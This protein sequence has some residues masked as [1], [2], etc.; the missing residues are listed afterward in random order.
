MKTDI[1]KHVSRFVLAGAI[2]GAAVMLFSSPAHAASL[3]LTSAGRSGFLD[4][5]FF[6]EGGTLSGTGVFPAF[7][8]VHPGGSAVTEAAY[9]TTANNVGDNGSSDTF[10]HSIQF[11]D[12]VLVNIGG[13]NYYQFLLDINEANNVTDQYLS[14]DDLV[15]VTSTVANQSTTPLPTGGSPKTIFDLSAANNIAL[16]F[17]LE[18]GSGKYDMNFFVPVS[19][20]TAQNVQPTDFV[21]LYSAFGGLGSITDNTHAG[22]YRDPVTLN[23]VATILPQGNYG[24]SDGFEEWA[25]NKTS[26]P[27]TDP[28]GCGGSGGESPVPEPASLILLG[29]GLAA[30]G[31]AAAR[32]RKAKKS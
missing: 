3:D 14:L 10:N 12:L 31:S 32:R 30:L 7:V 2:A 5:A 13:T 26:V 20:F 15:V 16:N 4:T 22:F 19:L 23:N 25:L 8:Q 17:N 1:C 9:N 21:Y 6:S 29:S 27:C 11:Q 28:N 24:A 18:P